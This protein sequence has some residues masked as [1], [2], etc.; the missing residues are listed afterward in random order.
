MRTGISPRCRLPRIGSAGLPNP[1]KIEIVAKHVLAMIAGQEI[2]GAWAHY[3]DV[4]SSEDWDSISDHM[5]VLAPFLETSQVA[6]AI[7]YF[8]RGPVQ[9]LSN[10]VPW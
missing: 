6:D 1:D 3:Q 10:P 7:R 9:R 8:Q 4:I 5:N 2:E